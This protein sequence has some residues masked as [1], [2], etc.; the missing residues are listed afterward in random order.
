MG[1]KGKILEIKTADLKATAPTFHD[2]SE[3][4]G[5]ALEVLR[6]SLAKAGGGLGRR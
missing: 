1:D 4:L 3:A 2:Q 6:A 5:T